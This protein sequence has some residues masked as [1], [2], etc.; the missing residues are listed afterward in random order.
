M[1]S[2]VKG[3]ARAIIV[4]TTVS[5]AIMELIDT[6]IVN[7][8][9][10]QISG[11]LGATIEDTSWVITSYA[12]ANVIIIP[13]T[14]F[15]ARLFGRKR[16]YI[17]SIL[18]F[19][20]ASY[21]CGQSGSLLTLVL[22]RF[23]QGIGGGALLSTSQGIL[24]DAFEPEKRA[25]AGGMFGM[26]IVLGPT[27]GPILGGIIVDNYSWPLIFNI[28]IP[29]GIVATLLTLRFIEETEEEKNP[30]RE[31]PKIDFIGIA[32]LAVGIGCLQYVLERGQSDDWFSDRTI[33]VLTI[34]SAIGLISF[35]YRQLTAHA[36]MIQLSLLKSRNLAAS[37]ILTFA[38][39]FGLF[40]SVFIFPVL[41]QR[42]LGYTPTDAGLGLV[43][44]AMVAIFVMPIIGKTVSSGTP[45]LVY[46]II[47]FTFFILHGY[48]SS[49]AN[50]DAGLPFFF[51]PQ[52]FRGLGTACLMVPLIN[53]AVVG[54]TPQ[55]MPSGIALT[56]MIRQLGGAFG[57][58]VMNTFVTNRVATHRNDLVSNLQINDPEA[59]QRL[60]QYKAGA[61]Q[62][63][64]NALSST[65]ASYRILDLTV[66][67]QSYLQAYL[68]GFMLISL[69]FICA[70]PFLFML[71][72]KKMDKATLQKV[73]EESH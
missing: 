14:G 56:N 60:G 21:M 42:V 25:I 54:L 35:V 57:I 33:L 15:F 46:V 50:L 49:L 36:P 48:T 51:W 30:N 58:A 12:I 62:G 61:I 38:V 11:N 37:N 2:P 47:G 70:I 68:E 66:M 1:S 17:A 40:G 24:F 18:I 59:I 13:L 39:G 3:F 23:I 31:K 65:E 67:K 55:Q 9:L 71:K 7:V 20:A 29:F 4:I 22:W 5:A 64:M 44:S 45:P 32:L 6:S 72:T 27:I 63:G 10:A 69:F 26:G 19:T 73:Q 8:A 28:N 43:P 16:Y 52:I 41:V 34:V 53:Q